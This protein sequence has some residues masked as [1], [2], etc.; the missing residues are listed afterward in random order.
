MRFLEMGERGGTG[1]TAHNRPAVL[2]EDARSSY[3]TAAGMN[4]Y[5]AKPIDAGA[6]RALL[7]QL[8]CFPR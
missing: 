5:L 1:G 7:T 4:D 3:G 2:F 6:L 8:I